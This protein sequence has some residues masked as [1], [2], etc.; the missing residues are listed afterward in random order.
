[1]KS[2]LYNKYNPEDSMS[3]ALKNLEEKIDGRDLETIAINAAIEALAQAAKAH[4]KTGKELEK[5]IDEAVKLA[6]SQ[7]CKSNNCGLINSLDGI[8]LINGQEK[9]AKALFANLVDYIKYLEIPGIIPVPA[10]RNFMCQS[11]ILQNWYA[12][13]ENENKIEDAPLLSI[14]LAQHKKASE[15]TAQE[16]LDAAA[17]NL[18]KAI[19]NGGF[20]IDENWQNILTTIESLYK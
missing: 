4:T 19:K 10:S 9:K 16:K 3:Q 8:L 5:A 12:D 11:K 13:C 7:L 6:I 18:A 20:Q 2:T 17:K 14:F 1:M 15:K